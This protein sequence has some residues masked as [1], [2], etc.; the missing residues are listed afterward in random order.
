MLGLAGR[1]TTSRSMSARK[2]EAG[3]GAGSSFWRQSSTSAI[4]GRVNLKTGH[5]SSTAA[6]AVGGTLSAA[7]TTPAK[8]GGTA[9]HSFE[10]FQAAFRILIQGLVRVDLKSRFLRVKVNKFF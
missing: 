4:P 3:L 6:Q 9:S 8:G 10:H 7:L 2:Q 1:T 5:G